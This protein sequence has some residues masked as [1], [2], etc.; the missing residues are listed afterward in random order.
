MTLGHMYKYEPPGGVWAS[1]NLP[2]TGFFRKH[3]PSGN[4]YLPT[5]NQL[6]NTFLPEIGVFQKYVSSKNKF[7]LEMYSFQNYASYGG[8]HEN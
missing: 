1:T 7:L 8:L 3:V 2:K 4:A 5:H 6:G